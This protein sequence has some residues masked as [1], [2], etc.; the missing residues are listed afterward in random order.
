MEPA[1]LQRFVIDRQVEELLGQETAHRAADLD[2]FE[3]LVILDAAAD[4]DK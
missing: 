3:T 2:G 4:I 1:G